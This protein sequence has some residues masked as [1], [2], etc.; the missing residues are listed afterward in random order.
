M[1]VVDVGSRISPRAH[2]IPAELCEIEPGLPY[3]GRLNGDDIVEMNKYAAQRPDM[4]ADDIVNRG[5]L[6]FGFIQPAPPIANF[7]ITI[8]SD[9]SV[10]PARQLPIPSL[11]YKMVRQIYV[12]AVG[13]SRTPS[14]TLQV[15]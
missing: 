3:R 10:I 6:N 5:L 12:V 11:V 15:R 1:P 13:T 8:S 7:G 4:S 2:Y 14:S 9:M